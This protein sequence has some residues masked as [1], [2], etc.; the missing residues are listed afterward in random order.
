MLHNV[1]VNIEA[2]SDYRSIIQL[3]LRTPLKKSQ[4]ELVSSESPG[5]TLFWC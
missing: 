4:F 3:D 2:Y 5:K 1:S